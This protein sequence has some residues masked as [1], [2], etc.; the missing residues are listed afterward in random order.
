MQGEKID[1]NWSFTEEEIDQYLSDPSV[2][3]VVGAKKHAV[4]YDFLADSFKKAN[5]ICAI[6]DFPVSDDEALSIAA[7]FS[8]QISKNGHDIEFRYISEKHCARFILAGAEDQVAAFMK[9]YYER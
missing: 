1:G 7:F 6:M 9:A 2:R 4:V 8:E 5:R 3:Q